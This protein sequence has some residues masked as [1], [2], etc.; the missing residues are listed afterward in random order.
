[1]RY[2]HSIAVAVYCVAAAVWVYW[3]LDRQV[4]FGRPA[5]GF[6]VLVVVGLLHVAAGLA[7]GRWWALLLPVAMVVL[8]LPL[9][10][11]RTNRGEPFPVWWGVLFWAPAFVVLLGLGIGVQRVRAR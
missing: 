1:M 4:F 10:Y 3:I 8:A 11:P 7:I 2:K 5:A 6:A 9:G